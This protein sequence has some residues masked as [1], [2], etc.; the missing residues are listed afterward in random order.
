MRI[1]ITN[2]YYV[3]NILV[4]CFIIFDFIS[5]S[6]QPGKKEVAVSFKGLE[7]LKGSLFSGY[8]VDM[9]SG[10]IIEARNENTRM[11]PASLSKV[12][13]TGA[14]LFQLGADFRYKTIIGIT[15]KIKEG[16]LSGKVVIS[17]GGDPTLGSKYFSSTVP[18]SVFWKIYRILEK[19]GI[20][21]VTD[22]IE[23]LTGS[24]KEP[25]YPSLRL[26]EDMS[27]YYGAP[28][29]C[30]SFLD[31]SF[32]VTLRSPSEPGKLCNVIKV[33]PDCGIL[34]DCRV[35]SAKSRKDSAYIYGY[36][37]L[38]TWCI[39][40]SIPAGRKRFTIKGALPFPEQTFGNMLL[41]Y[42][43]KHGIV[44]GSLSVSYS[45]SFTG[46]DVQILDVIESPPLKEIIRLTNKKS[47]NLFAD[48]L[49]LALAN[50]NGVMNTDW[51]MAREKFNYIWKLKLGDN[52]IHLHDGSGLSPYNSFTPV[53]MV[54]ALIVLNNSPQGKVFRSS[55]AVSGTD[56]TFRKMWNTQE[57]K[58]RISGKSGYMQ[59]VLGYAGYIT[60]GSGREFAFCI[61][62]NRFDNNVSEVREIIEKDVTRIIKEY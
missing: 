57:T 60:A 21:K 35:L 42:L 49:F 13:T 43:R 39:K 26:W 24:E 2:R 18:D 9:A 54:N 59:E 29:H 30:L 47:I 31:N 8:V 58:G 52:N 33:K 40:G 3:F 25:G 4:I 17:A 45:D 15:G 23:I 53:D 28:P 56:G 6:G 62:V 46:D 5:C 51:D 37:G 61:M 36:P 34:F 14:A 44:A 48:H 41:S 7:S 55:L 38:K 19:S 20:K 10:D 32:T 22:G 1:F 27:N 50:K 16:V 11:T 12:L